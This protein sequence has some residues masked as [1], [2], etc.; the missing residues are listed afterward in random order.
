MAILAAVQTLVLPQA[1]LSF[2]HGEPGP[3]KLHRLWRVARDAGDRFRR[4]PWRM[5]WLVKR[6]LWN[7]GEDPLPSLLPKT[8][9]NA[10]GEGDK[11]IQVGRKISGHRLVLCSRR[12]RGRRHP[13]L[14]QHSS[15]SQLL[16][17]ET[18]WSSQ[19]RISLLR[20]VEQTSSSLSS[21][22][23]VI[24]DLPELSGEQLDR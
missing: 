14:R 9:V 21:G 15:C 6:H 10:D 12:V 8:A 13:R 11:C 20:Q 5:G 16:W 19:T 17:C 7:G 23:D 18:R 2:R 22:C 1:A 3:P 24:E 4:E